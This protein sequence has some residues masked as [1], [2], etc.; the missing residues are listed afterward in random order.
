MLK[1]MRQGDNAFT[2]TREDG[3][4]VT[5]TRDQLTTTPYSPDL[6]DFT[7]GGAVIDPTEA[8]QFMTAAH[9][10]ARLHAIEEHIIEE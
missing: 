10:T 3:N 8:L 6:G 9:E 2:V 7:G 5:F 1:V 4:S